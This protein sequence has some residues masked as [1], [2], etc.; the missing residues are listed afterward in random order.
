MWYIRNI[1]KKNQKIRLQYTVVDL[2]FII[3]E[4]N[5]VHTGN[6]LFL[7]SIMLCYNYLTI[8]IQHQNVVIE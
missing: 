8:S 1:Y 4:S 5:I 2:P 6:D 3:V 7:R